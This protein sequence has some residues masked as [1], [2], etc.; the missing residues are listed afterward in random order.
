MPDRD[1]KRW[2]LGRFEVQV[3]RENPPET[4]T[5]AGPET[6]AV[7]S[8]FQQPPGTH[9][10][11]PAASPA[12][13]EG[14]SGRS[15]PLVHYLLFAPVAAVVVTLRTHYAGHATWWWVLLVVAVPCAVAYWF[16]MKRWKADAD[17]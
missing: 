14:A 6:A 7:S 11:E 1:V 12:A 10:D 2:R 8:V 4:D 5:E 16:V 17:G 3:E 9:S 15:R 13:P